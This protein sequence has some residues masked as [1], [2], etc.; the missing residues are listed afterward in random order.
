MHLQFVFE[1]VCAGMFVGNSFDNVPANA[2][3]A[4]SGVRLFTTSCIIVL[5]Y[6]QFQWCNGN[7]N[8]FEVSMPR[9]CSSLLVCF[10]LLCLVLLSMAFFPP[11]SQ[12]NANYSDFSLTQTIFKK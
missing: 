11:F 10:A 7:H 8:W 4:K 9:N 2:T 1:C 6:W 5:E 12:F 3:R